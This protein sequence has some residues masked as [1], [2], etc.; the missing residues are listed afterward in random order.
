[1]MIWMI[2]LFVKLFILM[3]FEFS[4]RCNL[5]DH[6]QSPKICLVGASN[7]VLL[8]STRLTQLYQANSLATTTTSTLPRIKFVVFRVSI[9]MLAK[10]LTRTRLRYFSMFRSC[11]G[12]LRTNRCFDLIASEISSLKSLSPDLLCLFRRFAVGYFEPV[13]QNLY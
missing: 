3:L 8:P 2:L 12:S 7:P 13:A 4:R 9:M 6:Y 10:H 1:M 11:H 5:S